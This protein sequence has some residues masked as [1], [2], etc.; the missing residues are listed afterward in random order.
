MIVPRDRLLWLTG[1]ACVPALTFAVAFGGASRGL[2]TVLFMIAL[3]AVADAAMAVARAADIDVE[4]PGPV[5]L[6]RGRRATIN[7]VLSDAARRVRTVRLGLALPPAIHSDS[8]ALDVLIPGDVEKSSVAWEC[9]PLERGR[10][11]LPTCHLEQSSPLGLWSVRKRTAVDAEIRVYPDL[12]VERDQLAAAFLNRGTFGM[13]AMRQVGKGREFE[14]LR[15]YVPGDD[16]DEIHWKATARRGRP[17]TKVYQI[18]R[19]QEVYVL[20]DTSR[21]SSRLAPGHTPGSSPRSR[22]DSAAHAGPRA[23]P[24]PTLLDRYVTAALILAMAAQRQ[25]DRFGLLLFGDGVQ[26]LLRAGAGAAHF[27]RCRDALYHVLP[28]LVTP[29]FDELCAVV[30]TRIRR[31]SLL[32]ILTSLDDPALAD[33]FLRGVEVIR[34]QHLVY[35]SMLRPAGANQLFSAPGVSSLD[36]CYG[37]LGG[38]ILWHGLRETGMRL[39]RRGVHFSQLENERLSAELVSQY[40]N[41]KRRQLL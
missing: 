37:A 19:T 14:K 36:D 15:E 30:R 28:R 25:G 13:H 9:V 27:G 7:V 22:F 1:A 38:H 10:F 2:W 18:E 41:V 17:I 31:R 34:R 29:D 11:I 4:I 8:E 24:P 20:I 12:L 3:T 33:A 32:L 39:Q 16:F 40:L 21:L 6:R 5:N 26:Q 23:G 35:V